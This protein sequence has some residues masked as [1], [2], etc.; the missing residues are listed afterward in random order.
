MIENDVDRSK[1]P[2]S[3]L[4]APIVAAGLA[5]PFIKP[6]VKPAIIGAA[7]GALGGSLSRPIN[8]NIEQAPQ[9]EEQERT[10]SISNH[11]IYFLN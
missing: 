8:I 10:F 3:P 11:L 6:L 7:A 4:V 5:K 9:D 2:M 1:L